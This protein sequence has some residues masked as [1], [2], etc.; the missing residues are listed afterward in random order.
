M[1]TYIIK[2]EQKRKV[3]GQKT[4]RNLIVNAA[5]KTQ[6]IDRAILYLDGYMQCT[7]IRM[8]VSMEM[9]SG[10]IVAMDSFSRD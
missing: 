3:D 9:E 10:D 8:D 5:N 4:I 7:T 1:T 6:A 2:V